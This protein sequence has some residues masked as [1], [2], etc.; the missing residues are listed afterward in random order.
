M[1]SRAELTAVTGSVFDMCAAGRLN[2][3]ITRRYPLQG[4][5]RAHRDLESRQTTGKLMLLSIEA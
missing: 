5:A 3:P 4:A 2:L 1:S